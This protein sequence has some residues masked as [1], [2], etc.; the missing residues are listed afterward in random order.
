MLVGNGRLGAAWRY[1]LNKLGVSLSQSR[2]DPTYG[3]TDIRGT[4]DHLIVIIANRHRT[5]QPKWSWRS[6]LK[7]LGQQVE[8]RQLTITHLTLVSST[9][10]YDGVTSGIVTAATPAC[11]QSEQGLGLFIAESLARRIAKYSH[12]VR[13]SGL[14]GPNYPT[15]QAILKRS[16]DR[17]RFGVHETVVKQTLTELLTTPIFDHTIDLLT[18]GFCYYGD[19]RY[20]VPHHPFI[21]QLATQHRILMRSRVVG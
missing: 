19:Q 16:A 15:Y 14:Y 12:I 2:L 7:G 18:D 17:P 11:P 5:G 6:I 10:V 13:A 8:R 1:E 21:A 20:K 9:R 4:I 3:L